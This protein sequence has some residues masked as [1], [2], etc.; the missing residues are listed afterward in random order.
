MTDYTK[1]FPCAEC[2][3]MVMANEKHTYKYCLEWKQKLEGENDINRKNIQN[4]SV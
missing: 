3:K 1:P 4:K 2:G